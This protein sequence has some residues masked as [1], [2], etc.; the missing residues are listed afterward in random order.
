MS[1]ELTRR[2]IALHQQVVRL[3][4]KM[5]ESGLDDPERIILQLLT[6]EFQTAI[7]LLSHSMPRLG[8]NEDAQKFLCGV[9]QVH[10]PASVRVSATQFR[11]IQSDI[12]M[13]CPHSFFF[14]VWGSVFNPTDST[15]VD[16]VYDDSATSA[17]KALEIAAIMRGD[18]TVDGFASIGVLMHLAMNNGWA[19]YPP[20][21]EYCLNAVCIR[22]IY[23]DEFINVG[24]R[25]TDPPIW[26]K[27]WPHRLANPLGH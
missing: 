1:E 16:V 26:P 24:M 4:E 21:S 8:S 27:R 3:R 25:A 12:L 17:I 23:S 2:T 5:Y 13:L 10:V 20:D 18:P 14:A 9:E 11:S 15:Y 7:G 22:Q 6:F 19:A